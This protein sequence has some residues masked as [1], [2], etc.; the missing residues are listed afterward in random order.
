MG[1][2]LGKLVNMYKLDLGG[3]CCNVLYRWLLLV[4]DM[5][6]YVCVVR[7]REFFRC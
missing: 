2:H 1:P 5:L 7:G 4:F 3:T 6:W